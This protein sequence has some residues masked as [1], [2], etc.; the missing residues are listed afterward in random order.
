MNP[1]EIT[2]EIGRLWR[3]EFKDDKKASK[4]YVK[5]AKKG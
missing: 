5:L 4:K 3:E 2:A 1:K